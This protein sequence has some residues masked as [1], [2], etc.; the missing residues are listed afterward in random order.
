M[1]SETGIHGEFR[2]Q[3]VPRP[4]PAEWE[5]ELFHIGQE[6]LTN[7]MRHAQASQFVAV[8]AYERTQVVFSLRDDG[9]G[10]DPA[11]AFREGIGLIG[12]HERANA[13]GAE[14]QVISAPGKGTEIVV[15]LR[16]DLQQSEKTSDSVWG[17]A[18]TSGRIT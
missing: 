4:L 8:L 2:L 6:A 11:A 10:F 5:H 16:A 13:I 3:G 14:L 1:T 17:E 15:L 12:M 7:A 18:T 9:K